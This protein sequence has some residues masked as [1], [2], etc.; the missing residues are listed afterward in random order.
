VLFCI[1]PY[2]SFTFDIIPCISLFPA[3]AE[4]QPKVYST[5][6]F[7]PAVQTCYSEAEGDFGFFD[8][9]F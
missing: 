4:Y 1:E 2:Y 5:L 6:L 8:E 9:E 3:P 7:P